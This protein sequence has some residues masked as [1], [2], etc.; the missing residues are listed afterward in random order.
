MATH[1]FWL[2]PLPRIDHA[3]SLDPDEAMHARKSLRLGAGD[4]IIV[5]DG[6][7]SA[8]AQIQEIRK[9]DVWIKLSE[10]S[11]SPEQKSPEIILYAPLI[12]QDRFEWLLEKATEVGVDTII[13]TLSEFAQVN[14][15]VAVAKRGRWERILREASKQ[16]QRPRLPK[17][18]DPVHVND[19]FQDLEETEGEINLVAALPAEVSAANTTSTEIKSSLGQSRNS[20][21]SLGVQISAAKI[22]RI[23]TG[24]EGGFSDYEIKAASKGVFQ[25]VDLGENIL[26]AETAAILLSGSVALMRN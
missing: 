21:L 8:R 24:P 26:R 6:Q 3:V 4:E 2:S 5:W 14:M 1:R 15:K 19:V 11:E 23:F 17:L 10:Y 25:F 18:L 9:G 12:K 16:C 13:P 7:R 20:V 22:V